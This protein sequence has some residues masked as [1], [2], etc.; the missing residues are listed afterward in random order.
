[1]NN[2]FVQGR[3]KSLNVDKMNSDYAA[4]DFSFLYVKDLLDQ[5]IASSTVTTDDNLPKYNIWT[6][7]D[8][9]R[10]QLIESVLKPS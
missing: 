5:E 3:N 8:S 2:V 1:M 7:S 6:V 10:V 4:L 9:E